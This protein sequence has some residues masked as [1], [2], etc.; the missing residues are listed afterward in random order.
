MTDYANYWHS[1][2][3][4]DN[5]KEIKP[6][7]TELPQFNQWFSPGKIDRI[8][9]IHDLNDRF[10]SAYGMTSQLSLWILSFFYPVNQFF[11][12]AAL[13]TADSI[14]PAGKSPDSFCRLY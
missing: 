2:G 6:D 4:N 1:K 14:F 3:K 13:Y 12:Q 9:Q 10:S 11:I 5:K 8:C 7:K